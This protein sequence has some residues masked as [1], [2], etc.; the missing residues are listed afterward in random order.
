MLVAAD[1]DPAVAYS[2]RALDAVGLGR[3]LLG[4]CIV[5]LERTHEVDVV[6]AVQARVYEDRPIRRRLETLGGPLLDRVL[7]R[8]AALE[9]IHRRGA[10]DGRAC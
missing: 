1:V 8:E 4:A 5:G 10:G 9:L 3:E 6:D 7:E 2:G